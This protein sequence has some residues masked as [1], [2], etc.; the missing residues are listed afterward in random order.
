MFDP[1]DNPEN[2]KAVTDSTHKVGDR[3]VKGERDYTITGFGPYYFWATDSRG[4]ER[5]LPG[6]LLK[7]MDVV[8]R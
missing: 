7:K 6:I 3:L 2:W 8:D 1:T 5:R 4:R